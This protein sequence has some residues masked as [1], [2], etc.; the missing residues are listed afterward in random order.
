MSLIKK[1]KDLID[2]EDENPGNTPDPEKIHLA[3]KGLDE[4]CS[5]I[6]ES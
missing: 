5:K 2:I 1:Y 3:F 4:V 6:P